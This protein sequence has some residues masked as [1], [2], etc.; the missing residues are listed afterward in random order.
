MKKKFFCFTIAVMMMSANSI[1]TQAQTLRMKAGMNISNMLMKDKYD[2][3]SDHFK[4]H[5]GYQLGITIQS[6][7]TNTMSVEGGVLWTTR[8]YSYSEQGWIEGVYVKLEQD[9]SLNYLYVPV[10][11]KATFNL[12]KANLYLKLGPYLSAGI[13]GE[14]HEEI[15]LD[16]ITDDATVDVEWGSDPK[17]DDLKVFDGG[18]NLGTGIEFG[19]V[20]IGVEY[21]HG[22]SNV[23]AITDEGFTMKNRNIGITLTYRISQ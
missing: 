11:A 21:D 20:E 9:V 17:S 13:L 8:G 1:Q 22:I 2:T 12:G 19:L 14:I 16:N 18:I 5:I 3:Y 4:S 10:T 15:Q 23:S 7:K 6:K